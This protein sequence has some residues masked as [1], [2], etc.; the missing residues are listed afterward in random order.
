MSVPKTNPDAPF[1]MTRASHAVL[2]VK[3][4]GA[5]RAFYVDAIGLVVSD[6]TKD[7]LFLRGVEEAAHHS[8]VLKRTSEAPVLVTAVMDDRAELGFGGPEVPYAGWIEYGGF[9]EGGRNSWAERPYL[10]GGRYFWPLA[11]SAGDEV[12]AAGEQTASEE[13]GRMTWPTPRE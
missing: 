5:S 7:A 2:T 8:L 3:D 9:R 12:K 4:L 10:P 13:I 1:N 6:E 11:S